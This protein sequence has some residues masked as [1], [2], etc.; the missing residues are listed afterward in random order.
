[1][2]LVQLLLATTLATIDQGLPY[3]LS[4]RDTMP[5]PGSILSA[6]L[7]RAF[8]NFN[9]TFVLFVAAVISLGLSEWVPVAGALLGS[10]SQHCVHYAPCPVAVIRGD[11]HP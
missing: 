7:L 2:G 6:R 8:K 10:V 1:M 5:P 4:P 9:E 3:N 11:R